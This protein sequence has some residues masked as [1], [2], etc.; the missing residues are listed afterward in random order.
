MKRLSEFYQETLPK[1]NFALLWKYFRNLTGANRIAF[2]STRVAPFDS[3]E[4]E[5]PLAGTSSVVVRIAGWL[6]PYY[7]WPDKLA[8]NYAD[9]Y[10]S[11]FI[12]TFLLAALAV[13]LA[14]FPLVAGWIGG[15]HHP[16]LTIC[17]ALEAL[18]IICILGLVFFTRNRR[19][20]G[21][22][23]DYRMTA[24]SVRQ[25]KL[26]LPLGGGK[27]FSGKAA[28]PAETGSRQ[29]T[30]MS[31]YV[32]S[33]ER[34]AGLP[35]ERLDARHLR[36][37]LGQ[38]A[39]LLDE[40]L[41]YHKRSTGIYS[42]IEKRLHHAGELTLWLTLGACLTHLIPVVLPVKFPEVFGNLLTFLCGFLPALGA[43]MAG[44]NHQG[45]FKRSAKT[46]S[47]MCRQLSHL[48]DETSQLLGEL[49]IGQ[50]LETESLFIRVTSLS[51]NIANLMI[52][53]VSDWKVVYQDRPP[54]LPA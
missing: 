24:E 21:R 43:S 17:M 28:G 6:R 27:P 26:F 44:I 38:Y 3:S 34:I 39:E 52:N 37:C 2:L 41:K 5:G 48:A 11:G 14:L 50:S 36:D 8:E 23:L 18:T 15:E 54:V 10:R 47:T 42:K 13:G 32:Q 46:S 30:W 53:E 19:W 29:A 7:E 20:H 9:R 16:G 45:E 25:L 1:R 51:R 31:W 33:I 12:L 22:W 40:Q 35:S 4:P 49:S